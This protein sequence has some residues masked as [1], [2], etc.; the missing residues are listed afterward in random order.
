MFS[1]IKFTKIVLLHYSNRYYPGNLV[2]RI[3]NINNDSD[4][5]LFVRVEMKIL[6]EINQIIL[7]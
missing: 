1:S 6:E 4:K 5:I 7:I 2:S 3:V